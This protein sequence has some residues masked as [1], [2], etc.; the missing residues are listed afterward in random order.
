M[1]KTILADAIS[2]ALGRG[3]GFE[4]NDCLFNYDVK[5]AKTDNTPDRLFSYKWLTGIIVILTIVFLLLGCSSPPPP[6]PVEWDKSQQMLNGSMPVWSEN[7][8]IVPADSVSGHW[9]KVLTDFQGDA[10]SY[11]ISVYYAIAHSP[12]I[13]VRSSDS[14]AFFRAKDWLRK[15]GA[16]GVIQY[17]FKDSCVTCA[18]TDI[19]F[20][21]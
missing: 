18:S 6:T 13:V 7:S 8:L 17:R 9:L 10:G 4:W 2:E 21:R 20:S 16:K 11:D 5:T 19:Y 15:N 3:N 14:G 12:E 1:K